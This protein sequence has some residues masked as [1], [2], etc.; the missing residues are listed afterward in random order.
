M[1]LSSENFNGYN[2]VGNRIEALKALTKLLLHEVESLEE[3][4]PSKIVKK[5]DFKIN[6]PDKVQ[7]YETDLICNALISVNGNQSKAAKILGVKNTT[8]HAKIKR[9]DIDSISVAGQHTSANTLEKA[10]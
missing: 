6:L 10:V 2:S 3:I 7:R 8:L 9:Y 5:E 1:E 4:S